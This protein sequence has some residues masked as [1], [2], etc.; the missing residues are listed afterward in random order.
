[1]N[2]NV[3]DLKTT[4]IYPCYPTGGDITI[5]DLHDDSYLIHDMTESH[6]GNIKIRRVGSIYKAADYAG[7]DD[8][9][10]KCEPLAYVKLFPELMSFEDNDFRPKFYSEIEEKLSA[11]F[12]TPE[13]LNSCDDSNPPVDIIQLH[14]LQVYL[15]YQGQSFIDFDGEFEC[16]ED[17]DYVRLQFDI[18]EFVELKDLFDK[19]VS[20]AKIDIGS[21]KFTSASDPSQYH[22]PREVGV[23]NITVPIHKFFKS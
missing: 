23:N 10:E 5:V 11:W 20:L 6:R 16:E 19:V 18:L 7:I 3:E 9:A 12:K 22:M 21:I 17:M 13:Y 2:K 4:L 8:F 14:S 15:N 1:M